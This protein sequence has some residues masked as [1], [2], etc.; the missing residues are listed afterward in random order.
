MTEEQKKKYEKAAEEY[1]PFGS[2]NPIGSGQRELFETRKRHFLAGVE[3]AHS[4][5]KKEGWNEAL[6]EIDI[7]IAPLFDGVHPY[8]HMTICEILKKL[9]K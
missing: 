7:E 8:L 9:R 3:H 2:L 6:I 4:E 1:S 5:G